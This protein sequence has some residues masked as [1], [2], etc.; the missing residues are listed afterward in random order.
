MDKILDFLKELKARASNPLISS[1]IISWLF[2]NWRILIGLIFYTN[3]QLKIDGYKSKIELIYLNYTRTNY[4]ILPVILALAYTVLFP[5]VKNY[6]QAFNSWIHSWGSDLEL[7]YAKKGKISVE[8]YLQLREIYSGRIT[9]LEKAIQVESTLFVENQELKAKITSLSNDKFSL[10]E[11]LS[12]I[13]EKSTIISYNGE[14]KMKYQNMDGEVK[15]ERAWISNSDISVLNEKS[16]YVP[17]F[18]ITSITYNPVTMEYVWIIEEIK[19]TRI[20]FIFFRPTNANNLHFLKSI[21][22]NSKILELEV[23]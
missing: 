17:L 15:Y 16:T 5:F 1:F 10:N 14:W 11:Q 18:K 2:V 6:V 12:F 19:T 4:L 20:Y 21:N 7:K 22:N 23:A 3:E 13:K 9:E 8:K